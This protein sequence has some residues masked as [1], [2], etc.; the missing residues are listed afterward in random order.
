[1]KRK[2]IF[3]K[4][5][6]KLRKSESI[7]SDIKSIA[8]LRYIAKE[9]VEYS[10]QAGGAATKAIRRDRVKSS[11]VPLAALGTFFLSTLCNAEF[12]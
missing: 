3:V 5:S 11:R 10:S 4:L 2:K 12:S 6:S 8:A 7:D 1:M 9:E